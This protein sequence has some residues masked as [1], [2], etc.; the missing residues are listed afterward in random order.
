[1]NITIAFYKGRGDILNKIVRWWTKSKYSHAELILNDR[2]TWISISP[3]ILSK[4][5]ASKKFF[6]SPVDWDFITLKVDAEQYQ[7]ILD[8]FDETKKSNIVTIT[9]F[10]I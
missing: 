6:A 3:K 7:T 5:E 10:A 9:I 4:I 8:F 2:E 1:M